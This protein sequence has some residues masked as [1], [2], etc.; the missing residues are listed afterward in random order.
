MNRSAVRAPVSA[1]SCRPLYLGL[2]R[3]GLGTGSVGRLGTGSVG[4]LETLGLETGS[5]GRHE[6]HL[7][8][9]RARG[10][11]R[12]RETG[13]FVRSGLGTGSAH[14]S[15]VWFG[16]FVRFCFTAKKISHNLTRLAL[17]CSAADGRSR[18]CDFTQLRSV[19][20][21]HTENAATL[22]PFV[23]CTH[24]PYEQCD[25]TTPAL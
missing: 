22:L 19:P 12:G 16:L 11:G 20:V 23:L 13:S 5:V 17:R 8:A 2:C 9:R 6:C 1:L 10:E 14:R 15:L 3:L 21:F 4:R 7:A 18:V 24:R 25:A